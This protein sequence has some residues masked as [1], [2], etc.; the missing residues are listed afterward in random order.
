MNQDAEGKQEVE[1]TARKEKK[2]EI[3][4][5]FTL[6]SS[7]HFLHDNNKKTHN[8]N[9]NIKH[10]SVIYYPGTHG[11]IARCIYKK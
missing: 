2:T 11:A 9:E 6:E 7:L 1:K 3:C 4:I 10:F 5:F 8:Q